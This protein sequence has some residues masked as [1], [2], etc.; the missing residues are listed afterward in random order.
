M[1]PALSPEELLAHAD[2]A[3]RAR[4]LTVTRAPDSTSPH[5]ARLYFESFT[6][7]G[8]PRHRNPLWQWLS[9]NRIVEVKMRRVKRD[10][11]GKPL[12]GEWSDGYRAGDRIIT[13]LFWSEEKQGYMTLSWNAVWQTPAG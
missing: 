3:G 8:A 5:I 13:H 4:I 6:K 9:P 12:P 2:I 10:E 1:P 7:G 11:S